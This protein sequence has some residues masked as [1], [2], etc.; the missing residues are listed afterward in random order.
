LDLNVL[1]KTGYFDYLRDNDRLLQEQDIAKL[2]EKFSKLNRIDR[3]NTFL[4]DNGYS[5]LEVDDK[6]CL[7]N[8]VL[9]HIL[10][11]KIGKEMINNCFNN[12]WKVDLVDELVQKYRIVKYFKHLPII[13]KRFGGN[14]YISLF[15]GLR[16]II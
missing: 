1:R 9:E 2:Q 10:K 11:F 15:S 7:K 14:I 4:C 13:D 12:E 8:K 6:G 3:F 16:Y 5:Y